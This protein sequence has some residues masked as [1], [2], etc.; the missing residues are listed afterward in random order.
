MSSGV[1]S[2]LVALAILALGIGGFVGGMRLGER[3]SE[4]GTD[5][6]TLDQ[7]SAAAPRDVAL[8]SPAGFTGFEDGALGGVVTRNGV[9]TAGE[10]GAFAV[11]TGSATLQLRTTSPA[12]MYRIA[13]V[14]GSL[15]AGDVVVVRLDED[16]AAEAVLRVPADL[17]EG[18]SRASDAP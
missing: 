9:V 14:D 12:R 5:T 1:R 15:A 8:R 6:L 11:Q 10:D 16:G 4:P 2:G 17:R 7:P 18:D 3:A 13:P